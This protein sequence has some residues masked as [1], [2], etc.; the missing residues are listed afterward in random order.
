MKIFIIGGGIAGVETAK[1]LS[2]FR[3]DNSLLGED[4]I[5]IVE[6]RGYDFAL[7]LSET[8][9]EPRKIY[10]E[11]NSK[12][13]I[14]YTVLSPLG[15]VVEGV[16][17][18]SDLALLQDQITEPLELEKM[19][20]FFAD[21]ITVTL[22]N[23]H[24]DPMAGLLD[25]SSDNTPCRLGE[26]FHY[27]DPETAKKYLRACIAFLRE[28]PG[29][30][31]DG[32]K[33]REHPHRST[34]YF[35]VKN[36][37][38]NLAKI[39][40]LHESLRE[41]YQRLISLDAANKVFGEAED[42]SRPMAIDEYSADFDASRVIA[43]FQTGEQVLDWPKFKVWMVGEIKADRAI[44]VR[45]NTQ[46]VDIKHSDKGLGF[47]VTLRD[48]FTGEEKTVQADM[49]VNAAWENIEW[50]DHKLG[51][52]MF[53]GSRT[54]RLKVMLKIRLPSG[55]DSEEHPKQH[56]FFCFGPLCALTVYKDGTAF[57]TYEP[58]TNVETSTSLTLPTLSDRLLH[59]G[60]TEEEKRNYAERIIRGA[61]AEEKQ[62]YLQKIIKEA[63]QVDAKKE[64]LPILLREILNPQLGQ[65]QIIKHAEAMMEH[66]LQLGERSDYVSYVPCLIDAP[67]YVGAS[68]YMPFLKDADFL[69]ARFGNVKIKGAVDKASL[70]DPHSPIHQRRESGVVEQMM[71]FIDNASMKLLY[72]L[73]NGRE[74]RDLIQAHKKAYV[75][76][77]EM[78]KD[79][80]KQ[81]PGTFNSGVAEQYFLKYLQLYS[82][83]Q[84]FNQPDAVIAQR[85]KDMA[86]VM[87]I[88]Q[89]ANL[90][91]LEHEDKSKGLKSKKSV[92]H[93]P[94]RRGFFDGNSDL[95]HSDDQALGA[96][97][98]EGRKMGS[99]RQG[100]DSAVA[101]PAVFPQGS[102]SS[103]GH[104]RSFSEGDA[105]AI[106]AS[107][108][109]SRSKSQPPGAASK[110]PGPVSG[111][112]SLS[113]FQGS[114]PKSIGQQELLLPPR[115][116]AR[117]G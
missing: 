95:T 94:P 60:A 106:P 22:Q 16:I 18:T 52:P 84:D 111:S 63:L 46:V 66:V 42:F 59:G 87:R 56:M 57:L 110:L 85:V 27:S 28:Y 26:G 19:R 78:T 75:K 76:I 83:A 49:V 43:G 107:R 80:I 113:L 114:T 6:S 7:K 100:K 61:P 90:A 99:G 5:C 21:I 8:K 10:L 79:I 13:S 44:Q 36:T 71:G 104:R 3:R 34:R 40:N 103:E 51:I 70:S 41:E 9:I 93:V 74:V 20:P 50:L 12:K 97:P 112:R 77:I 101:S 105:G 92:I 53:A 24:T 82:S 58:I 72:G 39:Y 32:D 108:V 15:E 38:V 4:E 54:N 64:N 55:F 86:Q 2:K 14:K 17:S 116:A 109:P 33:P 23:K 48:K 98:P 69:E 68:R 35:V 89:S 81:F 29:F 117:S 47:N 115:S 91:I 37:L 96:S 88:K 73:S 65:T 62:A 31:F 45:N 102:G 67:L 30:V 25:G 11:Y 1:Q